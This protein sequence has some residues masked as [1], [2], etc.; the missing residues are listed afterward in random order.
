MFHLFFLK[1]P[2][3]NLCASQLQHGGRFPQ[4]IDFIRKPVT[5]TVR[6]LLVKAWHRG[7][8]MNP[9]KRE[10]TAAGFPN[11]AF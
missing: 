1:T 6:L 8:L 4:V 11:R 2:D 7:T 9:A 10:D 3:Y 5:L